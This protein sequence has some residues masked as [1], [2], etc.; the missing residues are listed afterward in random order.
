VCSFYFLSQDPDIVEIKDDEKSGDNKDV[1]EESS[2][3]TDAAKPEE[4]KEDKEVKAEEG[5]KEKGEEEKKEKTGEEDEA[6]V[7]ME[8]LCGDDNI[9]ENGE[10]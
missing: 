6:E 3:T 7:R 9:E 1:K 10:E 4:G 8:V 5:D 2:S